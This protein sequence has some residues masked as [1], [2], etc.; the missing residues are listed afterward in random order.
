[1]ECH[2]NPPHKTEIIWDFEFGLRGYELMVRVR[3][4]LEQ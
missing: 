2:G 3:D 1:M 4:Q